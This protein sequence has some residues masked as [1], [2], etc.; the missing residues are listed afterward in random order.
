MVAMR[1]II[2]ITGIAI[3]AAA[4]VRAFPESSNTPQQAQQVE[5]LGAVARKL[6]QEKEK[7]H[8]KATK[9]YTND[10]LPRGDKG[11]GWIST[12]GASEGASAATAVSAAERGPAGRHDAAYYRA[13]MS[14]LEANLQLHQRELSVLEQKLAQS[15][16]VYYPNPT[17]TLMQEYSRKDIN[18]LTDQ[19]NAKKQQVAD[20][21]QAIA[22]L[23]QQLQREGGEPGWIVSTGR[24]SIGG[25][26]PPQPITAKPGTRE[27]WQQ[28]FQG[29]RQALADAKERQHLAEDELSLLQ[30]QKAQTLNP[31]FEASLAAQATA[32]Q[33]EADAARATVTKAQHALDELTKQFQAS[34][35]PADWGQ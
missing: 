16:M 20:D 6:R 23:Q 4:G 3:I 17:Q 19:V 27:Y 35:A 32:K 15:N 21:Q 25:L 24:R 30:I 9:T 7:E 10:N 5:T 8:L 22:A 34:G 28:R 12:A 11:F 18:K 31:G 14:E 2:A 33:A 13:K 29:A 26:P 1:R